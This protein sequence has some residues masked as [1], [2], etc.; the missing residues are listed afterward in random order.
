MIT[1]WYWHLPLQW[2]FTNSPSE[3]L[4]IVPKP[5]I[6]CLTLPVL[7]HQLQLWLPLHQWPSV[8]PHSAQPQLLSRPLRAF[9]TSATWWLLHLTQSSCSTRHNLGDLWNTASSCSQETFPRRLHLSD[10]GLVFITANFLAPDNSINCPR[11]FLP[12]LMIKPEAH[13]RAAEFGRP[14]SSQRLGGLAGD[15]S[16]VPSSAYHCLQ[17]QVQGWWHP[18]IHTFTQSCTHRHI[19]LN[20]VHI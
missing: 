12:L 3:A 10:A 16:L 15:L 4:F 19:S 17:L 1:L 18:Y 6:L 9:K 11:S 8:A 14:F 13:G 20:N 7:G 5:Q 2:G